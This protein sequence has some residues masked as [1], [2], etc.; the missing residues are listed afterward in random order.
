[1]TAIRIAAEAPRGAIA[2]A[3]LAV[4]RDLEATMGYHGMKVGGLDGRLFTVFAPPWWKVHLWVWWFWRTMVE[5]YLRK[6]LRRWWKPGGLETGVVEL[7]VGATAF[8]VRVYRDVTTWLVWSPP[9]PRPTMMGKMD[10]RPD[11]AL[12]PNSNVHPNERGL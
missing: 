8:P 1:M 5:R 9:P 2:G 12:P 4:E 3:T 10:E 11:E 6:L 7:R